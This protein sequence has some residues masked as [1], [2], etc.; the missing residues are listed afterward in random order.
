MQYN[1]KLASKNKSSVIIEPKK[2]KKK[3]KAFWKVHHNLIYPNKEMKIMI[4]YILYKIYSSYL[5]DRES[6]LERRNKK[7]A[8]VE[9][10]F[11][12]KARGNIAT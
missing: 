5:T 6:Q 7:I 9:V 8:F 4:L 10:F 2:Q 11:S 1:A 3:G 12:G